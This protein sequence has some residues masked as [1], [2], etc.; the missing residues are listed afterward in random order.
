MQVICYTIPW[1]VYIELG[2]SWAL[3]S[4][5]DTSFDLK[6]HGCRSD[7]WL[8]G[9]QDSRLTVSARYNSDRG[10]AATEYCND[11]TGT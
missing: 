7:L 2:G 8:F 1:L 9:H 4:V 3:H 10:W 6:L 5:L 11:R